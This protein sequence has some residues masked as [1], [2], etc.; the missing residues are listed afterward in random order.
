M[1]LPACTLSTSNP[2]ISVDRLSFIRRRTS[3]VTCFSA[4][5][6]FFVIAFFS[7]SISGQPSIQ[8]NPRPGKPRRFVRS[9]EH[10]HLRHIRAL[11]EASQRDHRQPP[12]AP[13]FPLLPLV[14]EPLHQFRL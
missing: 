9:Q 11:T 4:F 6:I 5:D 1:A 2:R 12:L 8:R 14:E 7:L 10:R 13:P 3:S